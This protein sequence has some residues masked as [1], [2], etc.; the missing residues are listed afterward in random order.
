M[1]ASWLCSLI[2]VCSAKIVSTFTAALH[3]PHIY[4]VKV[5]YCA[6]WHERSAPRCVEQLVQLQYGLRLGTA[7]PTRNEHQKKN[8]YD[9]PRLESR[10]TCAVTP[11]NK[12]PPV[13]AEKRSV[14]NRNLSVAAAFC[15]LPGAGKSRIV[16]LAHFSHTTVT[17][18]SESFLKSYIFDEC[19]TPNNPVANAKISACVRIPCQVIHVDGCIRKPIR[20]QQ[21]IPTPTLH[22]QCLPS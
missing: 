9:R 8:T 21:G 16:Q 14:P 1:R 15:H 22:F 18:E 19:S 6:R 12:T 20:N 2:A 10:C 3:G 5:E 11:Q 7:N 4:P 13:E 17:L